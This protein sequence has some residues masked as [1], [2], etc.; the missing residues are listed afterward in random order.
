MRRFLKQFGW[1]ISWLLLLWLVFGTITYNRV[2]YATAPWSWF[3]SDLNSGWNNYIDNLKDLSGVVYVKT[4]T[5]WVF[6]PWTSVDTW[7]SNTW[8]DI[9]VPSNKAVVWYAVSSSWNQTITWTKTFST[10]LWL[11]WSWLVWNDIQNLQTRQTDVAA[12]RPTLTTISWSTVQTRCFDW[13]S[14]MNEI[15]GNVE[16]PHD[17]YLWSWA[18]ISP[19]VHRWWTTTSATT[20]WKRYLEYTLNKVWTVYLT[21]TILSQTIYWITGWMR[22]LTEIDWDISISWYSFGDTVSF[23]IY[24]TPTWTDTYAWWMCLSQVWFHYQIDSLGSRQEYV[25]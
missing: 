18:V 5:T 2:Q 13:G 9:L 6:V 22:N 23:R 7:F 20:T 25:K 8:S 10:Y 1:V 11:A 16:I 3:N 24:R 19:H 12:Q 4:T 15:F 17:A 21:S 14:Q